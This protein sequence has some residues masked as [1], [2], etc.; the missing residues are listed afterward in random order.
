MST[1]PFPCTGGKR[2]QCSAH[3][4]VSPGPTPPPP[5]GRFHCLGCRTNPTPEGL[6]KKACR[7]TSSCWQRWRS[8]SRWR[9]KCGRPYSPAETSSPWA[10]RR[11]FAAAIALPS[12]GCRS[13]CCVGVASTVVRHGQPVY[14]A[15]RA[16][17][18]RSA[19]RS[20]RG[21]NPAPACLGIVPQRALCCRHA[22]CL[23]PA[24]AHLLRTPIHSSLPRQ[25]D[26]QSV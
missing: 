8:P 2:V 19:R 6:T 22:Q 12:C 9:P 13:A 4:Y 16:S 18:V 21:R 15:P 20:M 26:Q 23:W 25:P 10:P 11:M 7:R 3:T 5:A 1:E 24:V 14:P 17:C